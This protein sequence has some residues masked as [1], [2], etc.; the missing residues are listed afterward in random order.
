MFVYDM[1]RSLK[2]KKVIISEAC[3]VCVCVCLCECIARYVLFYSVCM[4]LYVHVN[5]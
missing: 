1:L 2:L 3:A 5:M 4:C